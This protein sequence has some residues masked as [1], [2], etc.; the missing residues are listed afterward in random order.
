[1]TYMIVIPECYLM[2]GLYLAYCKVNPSIARTAHHNMQVIGVY[3]VVL[4]T[5]ISRILKT[6]F[7]QSPIYTQL[8]EIFND[9]SC[10]FLNTYTWFP[11]H[12]LEA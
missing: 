5:H 4:K 7:R 8:L 2:C 9:V 11:F 3:S 6:H 1:M 12:T 10:S